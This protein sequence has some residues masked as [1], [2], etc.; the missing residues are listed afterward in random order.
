MQQQKYKQRRGSQGGGGYRRPTIY[1][2]LLI[3][4]HVYK[5]KLLVMII[6]IYTHTHTAKKNFLERKKFFSQG[7]YRFV[8]RNKLIAT[9]YYRHRK[10]E[11]SGTYSN[12]L[13]QRFKY[14]NK[15]TKQIIAKLIAKL[16]AVYFTLTMLCYNL[17]N[18]KDG[19]NY[20]E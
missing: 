7:L 19:V 16:I 5:Y 8:Q 18:E 4:K 6:D 3:I 1:F 13:R 15:I 9:Y 20:G 10:N 14:F 17:I 11:T 2:L 12:L